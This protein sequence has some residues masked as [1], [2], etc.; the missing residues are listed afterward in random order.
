MKKFLI[1][2]MIIHIGALT[3]YSQD[4]TAKEK[5]ELLAKNDFSKTRYKKAVKYGIEKEKYKAIVSTP[6]SDE[7][8][9]QGHYVC[10]DRNIRMD[11][12]QDA[13]GTW[14]VT[15]IE[16]DKRTALNDVRIKDAFFHAV[17]GNEDG[18]FQTWEGA[19]INRNDDGMIDFGLGIKLPVPITMNGLEIT[20]LFFKKQMR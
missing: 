9:Y 13:N 20:K 11:I 7:G 2:V 5:A 14:L 3:A 16:G 12:R 19:F 15:L 18:S 6:V 8:L 17:K 4:T 10:Q 1:P